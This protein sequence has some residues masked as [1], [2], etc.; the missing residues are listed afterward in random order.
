MEKGDPVFAFDPQEARKMIEKISWV[1][2]ARV[3]R[4]LPDTIYV[5]LEERN[6]MALWQKDGR[7][8]LVDDEGEIL[9]EGNPVDFRGLIMVYGRDAPQNAGELL[10]LLAAEPELKQQVRSAARISGRR[11]NLRLENGIK[12]LLPEKDMGLALRRMMQAHEEG[13]LLDKDIVNIDLRKADRLIV[14][15]RKGRAH[16]WQS[17]GQSGI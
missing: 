15:P 6:P 11:W 4:R 9:S 8:V 5:G 13:S 3:E 17:G 1:K 14:R 2:K 7:P 10:E 16:T 12:I